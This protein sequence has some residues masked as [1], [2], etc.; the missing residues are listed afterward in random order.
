MVDPN[1]QNKSE[2]SLVAHVMMS[3]CG[4]TGQENIQ[5]KTDH[6]KPISVSRSYMY[7]YISPSLFIRE[8]N[9]TICLHLQSM[10]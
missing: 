10:V 9:A 5:G 6:F 1:E 3:D 2:L 7:V 8:I 4:S